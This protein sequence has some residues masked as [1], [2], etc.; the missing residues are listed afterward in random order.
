M[1]ADTKI[2][3]SSDPHWYGYVQ[4]VSDN[5]QAL[6]ILW[7]YRPSDT[8]CLQVPY[9]D[10]KE[11]F[12]SDHCNCGDTP[13]YAPEVIR[14]P[15]VAFFTDS[16]TPEN[17]YYVRQRYVEAEG[18]WETLK[19]PDFYC[20][21]KDKKVA[22]EYAVG[23]TLLVKIKNLLEPVIL[24]E[25]HPG[26]SIGKIRVRRLLRKNRDYKDIKLRRMSLFSLVN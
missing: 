22:L 7:L 16:A 1:K 17:E 14:K 11:L 23:D 15:R 5:D 13:I 19:K 10:P 3:K 2:W 26:G 21:C 9:P 4:D 8:L 18:A 24:I 20:A 6:S 12:L 25:K